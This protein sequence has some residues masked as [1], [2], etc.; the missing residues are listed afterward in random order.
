[1]RRLVRL[2]DDREYLRRDGRVDPVHDA[3]VDG[4]PI[5]AV[6]A[7]AGVDV[8]N[9]VV[10]TKDG[11]EQGAPY[12]VVRLLKAEDGRDVLPDRNSVDGGSNGRGGG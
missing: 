5:R 11:H 12:G 8:V 10:R 9:E 3:R 1:M 4:G 6:E 7:E 2:H